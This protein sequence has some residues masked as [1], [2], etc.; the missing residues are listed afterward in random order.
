MC[1]LPKKLA[2][3]IQG[4]HLSFDEAKIKLQQNLYLNKEQAI[5]ELEIIEDLVE[6]M[7]SFDI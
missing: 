7:K 5:K 1:L 6:K 3:F 4:K 2:G